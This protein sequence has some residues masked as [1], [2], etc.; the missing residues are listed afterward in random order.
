MHLKINMHHFVRTTGGCRDNRTCFCVTGG[1]LSLCRWGG[2]GGGHG[3]KKGD[4]NEAGR[5]LNEKWGGQ[6]RE[7]WGYLHRAQPGF[8]V[9]SC[10][11]QAGTFHRGSKPHQHKKQSGIW[12]IL[13]PLK[14]FKRRKRQCSNRLLGT[15]A[16]QDERA[17]VTFIVLCS[18]GGAAGNSSFCCTPSTPLHTHTMENISDSPRATPTYPPPL[19]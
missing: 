6:I 19:P 16:V 11:Y 1:Q 17:H 2:G 4:G 10:V 15:S 14:L 13:I 3:G 8:V 12:F 7:R 9:Y 18:N 5:R